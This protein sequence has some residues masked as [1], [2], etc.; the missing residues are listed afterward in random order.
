APNLSMLLIQANCNEGACLDSGTGRLVTRDLPV[1]DYYLV[2]DG[3]AG[4]S[5]AFDITPICNSKVDPPTGSWTLNPGQTVHETKQVAVNADIT[6]G[7]V[8]FAMD[9]TG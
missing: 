2:V 7:D 1:G 4:A 8:M 6:R 3:L 9:M 5:G